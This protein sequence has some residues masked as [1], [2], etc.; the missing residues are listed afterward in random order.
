MFLLYVGI[1]VG[2]REGDGRGSGA[3]PCPVPLRLFF[4]LDPPFFLRIKT[5]LVFITGHDESLSE[6]EQLEHHSDAWWWTLLLQMLI[7]Q[8][9]N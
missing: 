9:V 8:I 4:A 6:L 3:Y 7:K 5:Y 2:K 1:W